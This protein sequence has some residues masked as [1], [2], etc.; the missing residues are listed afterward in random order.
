[1][2]EEVRLFQ[3]EIIHLV[4]FLEVLEQEVIAQVFEVLEARGLIIVLFDLQEI[5]DPI[6]VL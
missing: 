1:M 3:E 6:I 4:E 5:L 2:E